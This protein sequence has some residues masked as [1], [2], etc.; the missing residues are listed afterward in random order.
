[1]LF[2]CNVDDIGRFSDLNYFN[3]KYRCVR[4]VNMILLMLQRTFKLFSI[5]SSHPKVF[6]K[7]VLLEIS[8]NSQENTCARVWGWGLQLYE[9]RDSAAG[10]FC[11]FCESSKNTFSYKIHPVATS[12]YR[13]LKSLHVRSSL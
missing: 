13:F 9:K 3:F 1:M 2:F 6:C 8:E 10:V 11:E 7:K 12:K 4:C 5:W